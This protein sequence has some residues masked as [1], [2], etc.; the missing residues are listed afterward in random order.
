MFSQDN[1]VFDIINQEEQTVWVTGDGI[2][3][4]EVV[5]I[6]NY[7]VYNGEKYTVCKVKKSY[8]ETNGYLRKDKRFKRGYERITWTDSAEGFGRNLRELIIP[9]S[10]TTIEEGAF[11]N[12]TSLKSITIPSGITKIEKSL[13]KGC[14]S[15]C[16]INIA[17]NNPSYCSVN[18]VVFDKDKT[19]LVIYP[20]GLQG[21]YEIP[22]SV[23]TIEEGAF[24]GC[25]KLSDI[26]IPNSIKSIEKF[27]FANCDALSSIIIPNSVT[28]I[29]EGTFE[30]CTSLKSITI[31]SGIT[32]IEKSLFKGCTSLCTINIAENNPSY[33]SVNGVVFDKDKTKL[34]IYPQGLQGAY[35]IPDSVTTIEEGAFSGCSKLSDITIPNSIKSIEKFSFANCDALSS[36]IIPDS[37][38]TIEEGT[39]ENCTSLKS[40]TIPNGIVSIKN[41]A[42]MN[43]KALTSVTI[44]SGVKYIKQQAFYA[45]TSL[46][47]I[48][49][50][51]NV[52]KI[53]D[54]AFGGVWDA[55]EIYVMNKSTKIGKMER[56][57]Y[58]AEI[59]YPLVEAAIKRKKKQ[60]NIITW[61]IAIVAIIV[62]GLVL[63][64]W[65]VLS[66][67]GT[68]LLVGVAYFV[69]NRIENSSRRLKKVQI[70][71][72]IIAAIAIL[73][74]IVFWDWWA[75]LSAI[76]TI[77]I[78]GIISLMIV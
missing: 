17:E 25:S 44:G 3:T 15:L 21:A 39:F 74:Q 45:C 78:V 61:G 72:W 46:K 29:E 9:D 7:I 24:S 35:E 63:H 23:T 60:F 67:I 12:C 56:G 76:I 31:P 64:G 77:I 11:E 54:D 69:K 30:N 34:V 71:L 43:C 4:P 5:K 59:S 65:A 14:T 75:I 37:V 1:L 2:L 51:K 13:F 36:L 40:I 57:H 38:T 41:G 19:K 26:T 20:Q 47:S 6:P 73:L 53:E 48:T 58:E 32:K 10:I 22:D 49:I 33:C 27:S 66:G 70:A 42:F 16:T 68:L 28:T 62:Q 50:P 55:F 18:G 8:S 52:L